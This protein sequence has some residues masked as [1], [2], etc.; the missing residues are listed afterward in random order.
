MQVPLK[1]DSEKQALV[2]IVPFGLESY[3]AKD[4]A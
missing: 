4:L 3:K 2:L 1:T